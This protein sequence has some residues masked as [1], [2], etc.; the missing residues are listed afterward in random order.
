M[1]FFIRKGKAI[2]RGAAAMNTERLDAATLK[3]IGYDGAEYELYEDDGY[4][5]QNDIVSRIRKMV[6]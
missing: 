3:M 6:S 2:P 5:K 4:T 1:V